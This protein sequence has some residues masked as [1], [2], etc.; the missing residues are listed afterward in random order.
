MKD[1]KVTPYYRNQLMQ[2]LKEGKLTQRVKE[3]RAKYYLVLR[4]SEKYKTKWG[5]DGD[6]TLLTEE[7]IKSNRNAKG[8]P[9]DNYQVEVTVENRSLSNGLF[10]EQSSKTIKVQRGVFP[11]NKLED[12]AELMLIR[13][14]DNKNKLVE[15]YI[16]KYGD[17]SKSVI[18]EIND[19]TRNPRVTDFVN[20]TNVSF[21]TPG[22]NPLK[23]SYKM[24]AFD[25]I[26]EYNNNYIIKMFA[27]VIEDGRWVGEKYMLND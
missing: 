5:A 18:N 15:F 8:D 13:N 25:K 14:I 20:I 21:I 2:D 3:F 17:K 6:F 1:A 24:L 7:E 27:E 10:E 19:I 4:E 26:V 23:F 12:Y 11:K 16:P 9:Y 22:G